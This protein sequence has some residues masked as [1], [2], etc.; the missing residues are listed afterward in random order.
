MAA[1]PVVPD[2]F[3]PIVPESSW[4]RRLAPLGVRSIQL[5]LKDADDAEIARQISESLGIARA[6]GCQLIVNDYWRHAIDLGAEDIHLGQEDLASADLA[7][8][9]DAGLRLGVSTHDECELEVALTA[10]PDYIALGP[11]F[12]TKLKAMAWAPQGLERIGQWKARS[13]GLALVAIGGITLERAPD[14]LRAGA[15]SIAVVTDIVTHSEPENR[16]K[17][18]L[19]WAEQARL[20]SVD[21]N[22][23]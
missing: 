3:Y 17:E 4:V 22:T 11:I 10:G 5:R 8:I 13:G 14:V 2:L 7:A 9:K 15:D 20:V 6:H 21:K 19:A 23:Q 12:K 16:V 1:A 18:W